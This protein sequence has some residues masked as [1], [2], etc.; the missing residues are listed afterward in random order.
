MIYN[1][2]E[3][4]IIQGKNISTICFPW[5][6]CYF[7]WYHFVFRLDLLG[8]HACGAPFTAFSVSIHVETV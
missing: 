3:M 1:A 8:L 4:T 2:R 7:M 6:V 5:I